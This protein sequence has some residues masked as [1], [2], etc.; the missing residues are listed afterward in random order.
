MPNVK[1]S[2]LPVASLPLGGTESVP[3]VQSGV[4]K[5]TPLSTMQPTPGGSGTQL[6]YRLTASS[7]GGMTGSVWDDTNRALTITTGKITTTQF[8]LEAGSINAQAGTSYLLQDSDNGKVIILTNAL[9]ITLTCPA[10]LGAAFSCMIIQG[11]AGQVM[12]VAGAGATVSSFNGLVNLAG[13]Y[14]GANIVAA[15]ADAFIAM[16]A[17]V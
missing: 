15:T 7:F 5:Q 16:G 9:A 4:T 6:Q 1:I 12:I 17:L 2:Q 8:A 10:G 3:L 14:A 11:G 13:Q